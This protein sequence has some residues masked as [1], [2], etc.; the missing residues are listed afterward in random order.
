MSKGYLDVHLWNKQK[1]SIVLGVKVPLLITINVWMY[2][3]ERRTREGKEKGKES[4]CKLKL[5]Q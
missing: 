1:R 5:E 2:I 3:K 4:F